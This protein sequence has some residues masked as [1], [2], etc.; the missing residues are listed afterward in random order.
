MA[1]VFDDFMRKPSIMADMFECM[2]RHLAIR[3]VYQTAR[4][5]A[6]GAESDVR[7]LGLST[8]DLQGLSAEWLETMRQAALKGR[9]Q[10]VVELVGEIQK[11]HPRVADVLTSLA[12]DFRVDEIPGLLDRN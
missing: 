11:T 5:S 3:Y 8:N 1:S 4:L 2:A 7:S 9:S 10:Q 12:N 6:T